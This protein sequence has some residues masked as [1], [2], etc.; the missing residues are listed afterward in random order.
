M[1]GAT[2]GFKGYVEIEDPDSLG[3]YV[4]ITEHVTD[5]RQSFGR[6]L[7]DT[8]SFGQ[9]DETS[10]NGLRSLTVNGSQF[11]DATLRALLFAIIH[12]DEALRVRYGP[13]GN[14]TGKDRYVQ[15]MNLTGY[16]DGGNVTSAVGG[17]LNFTRTGAS[18]L[19][20]W[21]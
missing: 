4:D 19:D 1:D 3:T 7:V 18:T 9:G 11:M 2:H 12:Y 15:Y 20:T 6:A 13:E 16:D 10:V 17:A 8:N 21:P 5:F 14:A